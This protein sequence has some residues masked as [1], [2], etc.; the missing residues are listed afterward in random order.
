[1][2]PGAAIRTKLVRL[3]WPTAGRAAVYV[4]KGHK[5]LPAVRAHGCRW[6]ASRPQQV[7]QRQ[8]NGN[9]AVT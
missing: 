9:S 4:I 3:L 1:M 2:T 5:L 8:L 7:P 6:Q